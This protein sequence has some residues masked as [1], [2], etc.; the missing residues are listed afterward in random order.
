[1]LSAKASRGAQRR[2]HRGVAL[3]AWLERGIMAG[4]GGSDRLNA[5]LINS[6]RVEPDVVVVSRPFR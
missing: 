6:A 2:V 5:E 1:M 3:R 4:A